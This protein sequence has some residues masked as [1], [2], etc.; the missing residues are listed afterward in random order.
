LWG[1]NLSVAV[2]LVRTNESTGQLEI[3]LG[4]KE[5]G[6][7]LELPKGFV[8]PGEEPDAAV[9]RVLESETGWRPSNVESEVVFE[10][11]TYDPRQTDHAWVESRVSLIVAGSDLRRST[12]RPGGEFDEVKWW[13]LD[14]ETI[15]RVPSG[16]ARF[17]RESL[18]KLM[19]AGRM[20]KALAE[21]LLAATG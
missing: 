8:L 13:P 2:T 18:T 1:A 19:A 14:A 12:F 15:N 4:N 9:V 11:Y 6:Q 5:E 16:Q 7:D 20:E 3:L 21:S 10:G 17:V